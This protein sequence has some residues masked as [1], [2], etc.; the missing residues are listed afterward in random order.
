MKSILRNAFGGLILGLSLGG[1]AHAQVTLKFA[2]YAEADHP[3]NA[4]AQSFAKRVEERTQGQVTISIYPANA[5]GSPPEQL[6]QVK[7]GAIDMGLPTQGALDKYQ[8]AFA[9]VMLPF[10][11]ENITHAHRVMD[12][13][14]MKWLAPLAEKEGFV[15]LSNW[16]YGFRNITN[17]KRPINSPDDVKGLKLR[18]PPEVQLEAAME[19]LGANATKIALPELYMALSQKVVDGQENPMA[20]IMHNKFYEVQKHLALTRHAYNSMVH[21]IS[22]KTWAKLTSE[23][24]AILREESSA[25]G[26]AMRQAMAAEE[27]KLIERAK[28][29]GVQ[30]THPNPAVF[31]ALMDPAYQRIRT[32]AGA[33]NVEKFLQMVRS[34]RPN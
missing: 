26:S 7:L 2:H 8:K 15:L 21:V 16:E 22:M 6:Q 3:A 5:L 20:V 30:V 25:A 9:V 27:E 24:Q 23:Q 18:I 1:A 11:F 28:A 29:A 33:D 12:G 13:P 32:Y 17:S 10:V 14:A 34:E 31:R 19:A 4:A